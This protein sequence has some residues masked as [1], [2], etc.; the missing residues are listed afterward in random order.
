MRDGKRAAARSGAAPK[1][2]KPKGKEPGNKYEKARKFTESLYRAFNEERKEEASKNTEQHFTT[3]KEFE[4]RLT[5]IKASCTTSAGL[6]ID[7]YIS[8][9]EKLIRN[10][11]STIEELKEAKRN[12]EREGH[13]VAAA[14]CAVMIKEY[15]SNIKRVEEEIKAYSRNK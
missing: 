7:L 14:G 5:S 6:D 13:K 4:A 8:E 11:Q 3:S 12:N 1:Y 9:L 10:Q 15:E 2:K